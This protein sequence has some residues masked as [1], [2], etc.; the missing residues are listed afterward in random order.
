MS[1]L[2]LKRAL[3]GTPIPTSHDRHERL[4]RTAVFARWWQHLRHNQSAPLI[5]GALLFR[6]GAIVTH[7]PYHLAH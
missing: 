6:R 3:L 4:S 2:A 7:V 1:V 5:R